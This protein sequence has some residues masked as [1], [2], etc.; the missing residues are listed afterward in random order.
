LALRAALGPVFLR[1][2]RLFGSSLAAEISLRGSLRL[3][4]SARLIGGIDD[5]HGA[6]LSWLEAGFGPAHRL[7]L[8]RTLDLDAGV[9]AT[10]ALVHVGRAAAVD[11]IRRQ[12]ET[13]SARG[14]AALRLQP[15]LSRGLRWFIGAEGG[16][17]LRAIPVRFGDAAEARYRGGFLGLE[18]GVVLTP[19]S[20]PRAS[21]VGAARPPRQ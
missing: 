1:D 11:G 4:L 12:R 13:W 5:D 2:V 14:G 18:L 6:E 8:S 16:L 21:T 17:V 20:E 3:D 10:A 7:R 9:F 15:R 19:P